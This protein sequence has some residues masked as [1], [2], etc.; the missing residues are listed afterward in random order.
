MDIPQYEIKC[1]LGRGG[2]STV[3]LAV[4]KNLDRE[5]ALKVMAPALVA[6]EGFRQRFFKEGQTIASLAHPN[7]VT[8]HD[9]GASESYLYMALEYAEAGSTL[10]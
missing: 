8:V 5:I 2:M 4:Q 6:D 10:R 1:E 9:I 3:Y 7:I